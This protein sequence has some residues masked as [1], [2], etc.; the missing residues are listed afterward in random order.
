MSEAPSLTNIGEALS[1]ITSRF[2]AKG[3]EEPKRQA[4][5]LLC[6][7][8]DCGRAE[9]YQGSVH[10][11]KEGMLQQLVAW[12][13]RRLQGEPL[14]Y[15]SGKMSFYG[16]QFEINPSVLIPRQET[17]LLV[18]KIAKVLQREDLEGKILWDLC[19]GS[20]CIGIALKK[21][22]PMLTVS[23][24][25]VS[26]QA[27][28]LAKRNAKANDAEVSCLCG[29]LLAPFYGKKLIMSSPIRPIFPR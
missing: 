29:D 19:C 18:D 27:I 5:D 16:C 10:P 6:D 24:S 1:Y 23:L 26:P 3:M 7:F 20:G 8:L 22:L 4:Q 13:E 11:L 12:V 14:P 17:E 25:D 2:K 21:T 28:A 15:I 9:L